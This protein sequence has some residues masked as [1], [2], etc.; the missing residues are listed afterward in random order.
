MSPLNLVRVSVSMERTQ[1]RPEIAI[2]L[3]DGL[4]ALDRPDLAGAAIHAFPGGELPGKPNGACSLAESV[5]CTHRTF[6]PGML[7]ARRG[8]AAPFVTGAIA[9]L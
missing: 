4:V 3:T 6:V 8:S 5:A 7:S 9:L 1:G 2:A